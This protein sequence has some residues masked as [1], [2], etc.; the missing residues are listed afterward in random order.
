MII[1]GNGRLSPLLTESGGI[2]IPLINKTGADSVK[3]TLVNTDATIDLAINIVAADQPDIIGVVHQDGVPDGEKVLVVISGVAEVLIEDGT[4]ST[5][6]YWCR[7]S[8]TIP[9]RADI[10]NIEPPGGTINAIDAHFREIGHCLQ[11]KR[12]GID[13]LAKIILHFN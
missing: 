13:V 6:G 5:R 2:A 1:I 10:T 11:S 3:G 8:A 4:G 12:S 7:A 9:G